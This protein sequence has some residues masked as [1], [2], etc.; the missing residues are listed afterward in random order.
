MI[1]LLKPF[2]FLI[3][4]LLIV[5][6]TTFACAA[7]IVVDAGGSAVDLD[8]HHA[9]PVWPQTNVVSLVQSGLV[10][11]LVPL[12]AVLA[13]KKATPFFRASFFCCFK[14]DDAYRPPL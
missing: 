13:R 2:L 3:V 4:L 11:T 6:A 12:K 9:V 10:A 14:T 8:I 7:D 5:I 1:H